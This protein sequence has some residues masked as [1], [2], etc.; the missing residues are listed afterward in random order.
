MDMMLKRIFIAVLKRLEEQV[1]TEEIRLTLHIQ[2]HFTKNM[3]V[4]SSS[5]TNYIYIHELLG[6]FHI[7]CFVRIFL[8]ALFLKFYYP[9]H[10]SLNQVKSSKD[11][12]RIVGQDKTVS[13]Y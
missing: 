4:S 8:N 13:R 9:V 5:S 10:V 12:Y 7:R 2:H 6:H 11:R 1:E 3:H